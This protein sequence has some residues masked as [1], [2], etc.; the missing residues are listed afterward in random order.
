MESTRTSDEL[1]KAVE[2]QDQFMSF[3]S[4]EIRG[5]L[6]GAALL[7]EVVRRDLLRRGDGM[8]ETVADLESVRN[9]IHHT[10]TMME[11]ALFADRIRR[12]RVEPE[13]ATVALKPLLDDA[14]TKARKIPKEKTAEVEIAGTDV[15]IET[16]AGLLTRALVEL[17][18]NAMKFAQG[19][20]RVAVD[21]EGNECS[22]RIGHRGAEL[23]AETI[24]HL[25]DPAR[26]PTSTEKGVGL[27]S[28][29]Q[30]ARLLG[31]SIGASSNAT[32]TE[33]CITIPRERTGL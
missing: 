32:L 9:T 18:D 4:H 2:S 11:R 26:R 12:G 8:K 3:L 27:V 21:A 13:I 20:A 29:V 33:F 31:G 15:S 6:N 7:L 5:G 25:L 10:A 24:K 30:I 14:L 28:V 16:D 17:I 23:S 1:A 22:I 19:P